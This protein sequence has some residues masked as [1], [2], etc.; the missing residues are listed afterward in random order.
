MTLYHQ[1]A[2]QLGR[3]IQQGLYPA[4]AR[5]PGVRRLSV[6][7]GVSIATIVQAQQVLETQGVPALGITLNRNP[8]LR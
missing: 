7:F 8:C 2:N 4:H 5:L 6:Q 1:I 3:Q